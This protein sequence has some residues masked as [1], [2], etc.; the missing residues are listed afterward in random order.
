LPINAIEVLNITLDRP[1]SDIISNKDRFYVWARLK[2][3]RRKA[4]ELNH[5][6]PKALLPFT[7]IS[8]YGLWTT[9]MKNIL[10]ENAYFINYYQYI[11][12]ELTAE[13]KT[14]H[15]TLH[16]YDMFICPLESFFACN[17]PFGDMILPSR[18]QLNKSLKMVHV[19]LRLTNRS[20]TPPNLDYK[21]LMKILHLTFSNLC[22]NY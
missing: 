14:L 8:P 7:R 15:S 16:F 13:K 21:E 18:E 19:A 9:L 2:S 20:Y 4:I 5:W 1:N 11:A 10:N 6:D 12:A 22:T 17:T 3:V